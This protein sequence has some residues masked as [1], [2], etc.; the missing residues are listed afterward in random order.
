M[1]VVA[2]EELISECDKVE[3]VLVKKNWIFECDKKTQKYKKINF[4]PKAHELCK[5]HHYRVV[6]GKE[7]KD[8]SQF[9]IICQYSWE[10]C[11]I[12]WNMH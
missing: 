3:R 10:K 7:V 8:L 4:L 2:F 6:S 11:K 1:L 12:N 9:D 5:I